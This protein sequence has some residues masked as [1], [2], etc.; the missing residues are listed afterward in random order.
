MI[1]KSFLQHF[2]EYNLILNK[3]FLQSLC[4]TMQYD[5]FN[6]MSFIKQKV[7]KVLKNILGI[8]VKLICHLCISSHILIKL[9]HCN[10]ITVK[11]FFTMFH[12]GL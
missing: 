2:Y 4:Q 7:G 8:N 12:L 3:K 6:N 1:G 10:K 9:F 5:L 11:S